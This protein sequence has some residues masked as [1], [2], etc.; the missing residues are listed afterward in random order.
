MTTPFCLLH[1]VMCLFKMGLCALFPSNWV[2]EWFRW[3][4]NSFFCC[5]SESWTGKRVTWLIFSNK[6][7]PEVLQ[8][9]PLFLPRCI[10]K[11]SSLLWSPGGRPIVCGMD[12]FSMPSAATSHLSHTWKTVWQLTRVPWSGEWILSNIILSFKPGTFDKANLIS[13]L[14]FPWRLLLCSVLHVATVATE[15]V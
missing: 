14:L 15:S 9:C 13:S 10:W 3:A 1:A 5:L 6:P 2:T 12:I 4:I 7:L 8:A 11:M